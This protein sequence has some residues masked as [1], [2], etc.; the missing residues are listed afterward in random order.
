MWRLQIWSR[1]GPEYS[2]CVNES[3]RESNLFPLC[4]AYLCVN[5]LLDVNVPSRI[6][7]HFPLYFHS[8]LWCSIHYSRNLNVLVITLP[9]KEVF[10]LTGEKPKWSLSFFS[11]LSSSYQISFDPIVALHKIYRASGS[12]P[13][14]LCIP[15][16]W[17]V[18]DLS[19]VP[20]HR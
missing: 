4:R 17:A 7:C 3:V 12:R 16:H 8:S 13:A 19:W 15:F 20:L 9:R 10:D 1:S 6:V 5:T 18:T 2:V 11:F 14:Y